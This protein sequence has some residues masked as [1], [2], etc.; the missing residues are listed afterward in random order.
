MYYLTFLQSPR[1]VRD[2]NPADDDL[3]AVQLQL[4]E[5]IPAGFGVLG[6]QLYPDS[7]TLQP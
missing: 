3:R 1:K 7:H 6:L 4:E 2:P 5:P